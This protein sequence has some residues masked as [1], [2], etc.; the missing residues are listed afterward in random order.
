MSQR[1]MVQPSSPGAP[2]RRASRIARVGRAGE[3]RHGVV[4]R[5]ADPVVRREL[6]SPGSVA[7]GQREAAGRDADVGRGRVEAER[8]AE[9]AAGGRLE[10]E[11]Q[12]GLS[13]RAEAGAGPGAGEAGR[14]EA[15]GPLGS[16][17][18]RRRLRAVTS[19]RSRPALG[20]YS[21]VCICWPARRGG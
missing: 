14:A 8:R 18:G 11:A 5:L 9:A 7:A 2:R 17:R 15:R 4:L 16:V 3:A 20:T 10:R 13:L 12:A 19:A 21:T 1:R 6:E